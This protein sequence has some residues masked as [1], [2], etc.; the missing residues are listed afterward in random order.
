MARLGLREFTTKW[1]INRLVINTQMG[2]S[3]VLL[4]PAGNPPSMKGLATRP[5]S[6]SELLSA[7]DAGMGG[8]KELLGSAGECWPPLPLELLT[9][10][11]V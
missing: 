7:S 8:S 4:I 10:P 11:F 5:A 2:L 9:L 3:V 6:E 1:M